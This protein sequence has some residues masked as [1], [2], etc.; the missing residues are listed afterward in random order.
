MKLGGGGEN[1]YIGEV[2]W[3]KGEL[4]FLWEE[5]DLVLFLEKMR[6]TK[7]GVNLGI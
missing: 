1:W 3:R 2:G 5:L 4:V 7:H 6:N